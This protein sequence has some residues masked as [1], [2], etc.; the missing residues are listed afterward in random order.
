MESQ[1]SNKPI[2]YVVAGTNPEFMRYS[3]DH[4]DFNCIMISD[5][6]SLRGRGPGKV[7][8]IGTYDERWN[9]Q[10]IEEQIERQEAIWNTENDHTPD[11]GEDDDK[12]I[13]DYGI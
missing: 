4:Q 9:I 2:L 7:V 11:L 10:D 5:G 13:Y 6:E 3:Q 8:R 1:Q 12:E